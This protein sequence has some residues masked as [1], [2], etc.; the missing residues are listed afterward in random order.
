MPLAELQHRMRNALF[1]PAGADLAGVL[2]GGQ[3]P[4][5]RFA[6]H[7]RHVGSSL[8]SAVVGRF[9][10]TSWLIG[11]RRIEAAARAYIHRFPP[12]AP[13]I[14]EYGETF[15]EFLASCPDTAHLRYLPDFAALDWHVG[16]V[17]IEVTRPAFDRSALVGVD[18]EALPQ[19]AV[20][21]QP[22]LHY[23]G[24]HWDLDGLLQQFFADHA[25]ERWHLREEEVFMEVRG[26]RG[27]FQLS[28]LDPATFTFREA[29]MVGSSL[30][31]AATAATA[32]NPTFDPGVALLALIDERLLT[33]LVS[34][35]GVPA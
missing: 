9:P 28:R 24:T 34:Q 17:A 26:A 4:A 23:H 21:L 14:A 19:M 10:A 29:L 1:A 20:G 5:R 27:A 35:S 31:T 22:G 13:C 33:A 7:Q 32:V 30:G 6:I 8:T 11:G 15:P 25:A 16:R 18:A 12:V 2:Q 3:H